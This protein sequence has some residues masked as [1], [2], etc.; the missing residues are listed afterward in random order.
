MKSKPHYVEG[1]QAQANFEHNLTA[2]FK[3]PKAAIGKDRKPAKKRKSKH[4][5]K[6]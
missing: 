6:D 4:S 2:L 5:D 3:V 1:P